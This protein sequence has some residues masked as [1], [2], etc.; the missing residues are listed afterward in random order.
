MNQIENQF[1]TLSSKTSEKKM[2]KEQIKNALNAMATFTTGQGVN[3]LNGF[4]S[5]PQFNLNDS[6]MGK[7]KQ[8]QRIMFGQTGG[9]QSKSFIK[10]MDSSEG[11]KG[12]SRS[13]QSNQYNQMSNSLSPGTRA[14][15]DNLFQNK[16]QN[17]NMTTTDYPM[18]DDMVMTHT[19]TLQFGRS[20]MK[21][22]SRQK[23]L[24]D[25]VLYQKYLQDKMKEDHVNDVR[26]QATMKAAATNF[27]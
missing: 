7:R 19:S 1:P 13:P 25:Q 11:S 2:N 6:L 16:K 3:P 4:G 8:T 9:M 22:K 27:G 26:Q 18:N 5:I 17:L 15:L 20:S 21:D 10:E 14:S 23:S 24:W 12:G